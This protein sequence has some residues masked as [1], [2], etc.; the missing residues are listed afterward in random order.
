VDAEAVVAAAAVATVVA[1]DWE[2]QH[3]S[4]A[5]LNPVMLRR[6]R[7]NFVDD[8]RDLVA[9]DG[10]VGRGDLSR[11]QPYI[12]S[13]DAACLNAYEEIVACEWSGRNGFDAEVA[14]VVEHRSLYGWGQRSFSS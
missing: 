11:E 7:P 2:F 5:E 14:W 1:P 4:V 10:G 6:T 8:A 13:T 12:G 3:N 9:D